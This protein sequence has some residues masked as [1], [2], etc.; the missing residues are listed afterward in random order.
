MPLLSCFINQIHIL[1][2]LHNCFDF[3]KKL[4]PLILQKPNYQ[5][6]IYYDF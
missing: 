4:F 1:V 3:Q 5:D 6:Q 2:L